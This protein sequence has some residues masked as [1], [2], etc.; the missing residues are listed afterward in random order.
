MKLMTSKEGKMNN[1]AQFMICPFSIPRFGVCRD[2]VRSQPTKLFL[3]AFSWGILFLNRNRKAMPSL[4]IE[5][6][7]MIEPQGQSK[8]SSISSE[9]IERPE[10]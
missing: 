4:E 10:A 7:N 6:V 9:E 1:R 3:N 5:S 8:G 2:P